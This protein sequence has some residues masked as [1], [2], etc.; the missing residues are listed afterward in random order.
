MPNKYFEKLK[1]YLDKNSSFETVLNLIDWDNETLAPIESSEYTSKTVGIIS[2]EYFKSIINDEV[3]NT[4][5]KLN[6]EK[7][8]EKLTCIEKSI[9]KELNKKYDELESIPKEEYVK[10][11]ELTSKAV[12]IW[13]KAKEK[14]DF[15]IFAPIL[16]EILEFNKKFAKYRLKS[17]T[18]KYRKD[19]K[20]DVVLYDVILNDFEEGF[21]TKQLDE[22]F[23][24]I[25]KELIPVVKKAVKDSEKIDDKFNSL[26]Y[27]I[28]KQE[29]F[30]NWLAGYLGFDFNKGVIARSAHPFTT[31]LHNHDVRITNHFYENNLISAIFSVIHETGHALYEM[32]IGNDITQTI[33]GTGSSIGIHESQSRFME[34]QIGK[35]KTFWKPIYSKLQDT[36]KEQLQDVSL[37]DFI[38]VIN[39]SAVNI[40]RTE[41][42]ELTYSFHIIIRYE[43]EKMLFS[44]EITIEDLPKI[45][46]KKYEEYLGIKPK[47]DGEG[48]LQDIHW[49]CGNFGYFPSYALGNAI[50]AQIFSHMKS[51]MPIDEYLE[52]GNLTP[53]V[54][55]L[56]EHIHKYGKMKKTNE[57]LE[58]MMNEKLD[59]KYYID[60]LKE[61]YN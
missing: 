47:N 34:N 22:F 51:I 37:D 2:D 48:V 26:K 30:C 32:N 57:F 7:E 8:F 42:D 21:T 3:K 56:R 4:L 58:E 54:E 14:S 38:K 35:S 49:A 60:Y 5:K 17:Y 11:K 55:Y 45:W 24:K 9:I 27:D 1:P 15:S 44:D 41:A 16:K 12:N 13:T 52:N 10:F 53:I 59:V 50:A 61:K 18:E 43:L 6:N 31:S 19:D 39:K 33:I 23:E 46:N 29:K 28:D 20:K 36:F 40:T 25:K